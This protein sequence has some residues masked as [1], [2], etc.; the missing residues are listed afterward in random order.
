MM[1]NCN[2]DIA[3]FAGGCFWCLE[4]V[5]SIFDGIL[6]IIPG[7]A[8]GHTKN[9]SYEDVCGGDTGHAET[10]RITFDPS[11]IT[12]R[13]L[14]QIFFSAHNPTELNRRG[15]NIGNQDRSAIFYSSSE[16]ESQALQYIQEITKNGLYKDP[17]V[18]EV[19]QL[20]SFYEAEKYHHQYFKNHPDKAYCQLAIQPKISKIKKEFKV[21]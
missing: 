6:E 14:L 5:F 17:I 10:V 21:L 8:G 1:N 11:V 20:E 18:T 19:F 9:P 13:E 7:Y 16:Q 15:D 2:K 4:A 12:Y 3:V